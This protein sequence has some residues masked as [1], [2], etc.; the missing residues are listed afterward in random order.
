MYGGLALL[1]TVPLSVEFFRLDWP[2]PDLLAASLL[3][4]IAGSLAV[5]AVK[6]HQRGRIPSVRTH[7]E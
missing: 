7:Q 3:A 5:E 6:H 4:A 1:F 2:P